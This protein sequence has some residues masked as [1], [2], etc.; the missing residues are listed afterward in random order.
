MGGEKEIY[1]SSSNDI[2]NSFDPEKFIYVLRK[3]WWWGLIF[4]VLSIATA[5]LIVRYTKPVYESK[6]ILK[7]EF[8]SEAS[9]LGLGT[10]LEALEMNE[11]SGEIELL[12]SR[13]FFSK[14]VDVIDMDVSY[15]YRGEFLV[16]E[17]YRNSPF[18]VSHLIKDASLL[19][20]PFDLIIKDRESYDLIYNIGGREYR[21]TH[22]FGE[23]IKTDQFNLLIERT[24][25]FE[26]NSII[27]RY[28]FTINS[29]DALINY[30]QENVNVRPENFNAKTIQ[31]SLQDFN[32]YK[33][34]DF[35][36]AI[37]TLY[38]AYTKE[39]KNK[40]LE[41]KIGFLDSQIKATEARLESFEDYF[42]SFI[43]QN[44]TTNLQSDLART[45]ET[46]NML[47]SQQFHI[48]SKLSEID[49]LVKQ[50]DAERPMTINPMFI[51]YLPEILSEEIQTYLEI[52]NERELKLES[53]NENTFVI[54]RLNTRL[55]TVRNNLLDL[56]RDYKQ[57]LVD[58]LKAL[59]S[60]KNRLEGNFVELPTMGTEYNKNRRLYSLQENFLLSLRQSKMELEIT[61]AGTVPK[62]VILSPA[63]LG[64]DP[65]KPQPFLIMGIG[66]TFGLVVSLIFIMVSYLLHNKITSLKEL[67]R[68]IDVPVMGAVPYYSREK[69]NNS[70]LVVRHDSKSA[71]SESLRTI[72]TNMEFLKGSD[73]Q[74]IITVTSTVSGE[75]KT[76]VAANMGAIVALSNQRVCL[77]DMDMRKPK[78]HLAFEKE[79]G[80]LGVSTLL[81]GKNNLKECI[82]PTQIKNLDFISAGP[83]P[84]NPSELILNKEFDQL[85]SKLKEEY[86]MII[87][88]TP[89][90]G[91]VTDAVQ[92]M[93]KS[94][95]QLYVM[96]ADF[97]KRSFVKS[98]DNLKKINQFSNLTVV[99]NSLKS[100][101]R[102]Y[103]YGYGSGY[104][105]YEEGKS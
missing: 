91:L 23:S 34:R 101:G 82:R 102:G 75:G 51:N 16:D 63:S 60:R 85:L 62:S 79:N 47:D 93:K 78:V 74:S 3:R 43:I 71:I 88:D 52:Q 67:E 73:E 54:S 33:A 104:G 31:I 105:Y 2:L 45:I 56:T 81:I 8:E 48:R 97:S 1:G 15:Y 22:E 26:G 30:F 95:L 98:I 99:F 20:K 40:A 72:R 58:Q 36:T 96:R 68:L 29:E 17:R 5:Y 92:S 87:L 42:E 13:L 39:N 46:L 70:K 76:F 35:V 53:Y 89:P 83:I 28:Y 57:N 24:N 12:K 90:V 44:R 11:I 86:D 100:N 32:K 25:H 37:D 55:Q 77:L 61:K 4:F 9:S 59:Q 84:P 27:G 49:V 103:G 21:S 94:D 64:S 50:L 80:A 66:T 7:L 41:Q 6:S 38:L 65:I 69:M 10:N 18:V 19:D 14:V